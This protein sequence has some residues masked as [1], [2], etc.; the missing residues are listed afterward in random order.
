M[1]VDDDRAG[2]K[3]PVTEHGSAPERVWPAPVYAWYV[4]GVLLIA[5]ILAFVD[6]DVI[7]MLV[8]PIKRDLDIG[9]TQMS[10]LLGGAFALFYT[11]FGMPIAWLSD[12]WN[13]RY[14]IF[15]GVLLWSFM[16]VL[17]GMSNSYWALFLARVGVGVGEAALN[18]AALSI[19]KDYFPPRRLGSAVGV[20]TAGIS[21]GTG[22]GSILSAS[23]YPAVALGGAVTLPLLGQLDPWQLMFVIVGVPGLLVALLVLTI[24]EPARTA[25][26]TPAARP[27]SIRETFAY[28]RS[29]RSTYGLLFLAMSVPATMNYGVGYWVPEFLRRTYDLDV[30]ALS[31][32]LQWRGVALIV[33]GLGGVLIGGLLCDTLIRKYD[34]GYIRA[35][36]IGFGFLALGYVSMPLMPTPELAVLMLIPA[37]I[38]GAIP[39]VAGAASVLA[40]APAGMRAQITA[41]YYF[42]LNVIGLAI[43]PS[44]VALLTE[45]VFGDELGLRKSLVIVAATSIAAG[46]LLLWRARSPYAASYRESQRVNGGI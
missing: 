5:Y 20:Y 46:L 23:A 7:A 32:F 37:V 16:T 22:I 31:S 14:I 33:A 44:L 17:C 26:A 2:S 38:G 18:P 19:L 10:L 6:R 27:A 34:D 9:D 41:M 15:L 3:R 11:F 43:G 28:V 24:R 29:R 39:T 1:S 40:I 45:H 4:V 30:V 35:S 12:R 8:D 25:A 36:L 13:R 21:C 42:V